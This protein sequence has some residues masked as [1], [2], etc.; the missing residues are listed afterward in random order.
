MSRSKR[1]I[2]GILSGYGSIAAN[3]VVAMA[4]I[5]L[6]LHYLDKEHFGLWALAAQINGYLM[7]IDAGMNGAVSRFIADHKDDVNGGE[8]GSQLLTGGSVFAIQGLLIA[9]VGIGFSWFAPSIFAIPENLTNDFRGLLMLLAGFTGFSVASRSFGA[10]LWAFNRYDV[11]NNLST[12]SILVNLILLWYGFRSNWG[13]FSFAIAQVPMLFISPAT[14][15]WVCHRNRYYPMAGHWGKV[16]FSIFKQTFHYGKDALMIQLGSQL[17]NASQIMII[18]RLVSLEA[19]AT[20][21]VSIKI[22]TMGMML[23]VNPISVAGPGLT[24]LYVRGEITRFI[25]RYWE[26]IALTLAVS[27]L[28]AVGIATGNRSFVNL[29]THG[30]IEWPWTGDLILALLIVLRTLN[31]CFLNLFGLT[32]NWQPVRYVYLAEGLVFVPCAVM[33]A[34]PYGVSGVLIASLIAHVIAT[35]T[36]SARA[37]SRVIGSP[38]KLAKG[39]VVSFSLITVASTLNW[40][41]TKISIHPFPMLAATACT[42]LIAIPLIWFMILPANFRNE[43]RTRLALATGK[44]FKPLFRTH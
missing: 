15:V 1:F 19:A 16:S 42:C 6:A 7:L 36:L 21:A 33:L 40:G 24:E 37:A 12:L 14:C 10:P 5:P 2:T 32:K 17:I 8:Y 11:L 35:T 26:I 34:K 31:G 9:S 29:W 28:V 39:L 22:Y 18:T 30:R 27:T 13:V 25:Q 4:S 43:A 3:I 20:F 41:A 44:I 23:I 38:V